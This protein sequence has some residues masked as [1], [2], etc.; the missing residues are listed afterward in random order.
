MEKV[1]RIEKEKK[2]VKEYHI[3]KYSNINSVA[4]KAGFYNYKNKITRYLSENF[5]YELKK[6]EES[7]KKIF[8][9]FER[10]ASVKNKNIPQIVV[11]HFI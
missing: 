2:F 7:I 8:D 1:I 11:P 4:R 3:S 6:I 10:E 5:D 9:I